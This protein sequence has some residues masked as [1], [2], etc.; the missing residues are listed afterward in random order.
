M[1]RIAHGL[2]GVL[3]LGASAACTAVITTKPPVEGP[4][5]GAAPG[6]SGYFIVT[7][8]DT[9]LCATPRCGGYFV[10][11]VNEPATLCADGTRMEE[12]HVYDVD[13]SPAGL[14]GAE[15]EAFEQ[16]FGQGNGLARGTLRLTRDEYGNPVDT[17]S[18]SEAWRG[19]ARSAP[20]GDFYRVAD[21]GIECITFPCFSLLEERLNTL[22]RGPL[23]G[24]DLAAS[25]AGSAQV[26]RG[27]AELAATGILAA[28]THRTITGPAGVGT[29]LIAS[30]FYSRVLPSRP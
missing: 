4:G 12:C 8:P 3:F 10:K 17:L 2:A 28:G 1:R 21:A 15:A 20:A 18:A 9:R 23:A 25:G 16:R 27:F 5:P 11:L 14:R 22:E 19:V 6:A 24:I 29:Q 7:R 30:E 13:L 26:S